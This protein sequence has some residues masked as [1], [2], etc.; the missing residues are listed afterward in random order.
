[1]LIDMDFKIM[2]RGAG[3]SVSSIQEMP[4]KNLT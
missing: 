3:A 1:M 2:Y 4:T